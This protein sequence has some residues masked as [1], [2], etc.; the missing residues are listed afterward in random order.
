MTPIMHNGRQIGN[1]YMGISLEEVIASTSRSRSTVALVSIVIFLVGMIV[2]FGISTVM[3]GGLRQMVDTVQK[4]AGGDLNQRASVASRD[5]VGNLAKSFNRMVDNLETA[6]QE[7]E[8]MNR[9]LEQRVEERTAELQ[10]EIKEREKAEQNLLHA[11]RM[12]TIGNLAGGVAH[13]FNNILG[14]ILGYITML[15][16][17]DIDREQMAKSLEIVHTATQRGAGLVKQLLTFARKT[18]VHLESVSI[19]D[20]VLEI[21]KLLLETFPKTIT[22]TLD[23]APDLPLI[24]ADHNQIHQTVLNLCV[25]ARDA[26]LGGG[27]L[28]IK[29]NSISGGD[30]RRRFEEAIEAE[31]V[32]IQVADTGSGID[33]KTKDHIFEPF[34]TTKE[35]GRGT[36]LG[37]SVVYGVV[38]YHRGFIDVQSKIGE[39]TTF[40]IYFPV[41]FQKPEAPRVKESRS[42]QGGQEIVLLV[43]DEDALLGLL[44]MVV[45]GRGYRTL[46]A[47]DGE[48]AVA[49]FMNHREDIQ[50]VLTDMGLPRLGGFEACLK[51][52]KINPKLK[53]LFA[54]G[55]LDPRIRGEM[56]KMDAVDFVQKPYAPAEVLK[57]MRELLDKK[58]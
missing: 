1:L 45:E 30:L 26:M 44:Q 22:L 43:E 56:Q 18:D 57:K 7:L 51:M 39:G 2:T 5:E 42:T 41:P 13:D 28:S 31:Y 29:T 8:N 49:T 54:S 23:P 50:L 40:T 11:Q 25:N 35:R 21:H 12:E 46:A 6:R 4:I 58:A 47:R 55:F 53:I 9:T 3:T 16:N 15:Q 17:E 38:N 14:I 37:L 24:S 34:F 33:E 36:G 27:I 10:K 19:N 20:V 48:E 52:R 32:S